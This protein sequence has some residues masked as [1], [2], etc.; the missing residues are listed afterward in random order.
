MVYVISKSGKPLMP[1]KEAKARKLLQDG[2]AKC[3]RRTPFTIKLN[4]DCEE[5]VQEVVAG[6]DTGSKI[7]GCACISNGQVLYQ[8]EVHL[9]TDIKTR[10]DRRRMYRRT[11]RNRKCR[12][13]K[14]RWANRASMKRKGKLSP[15]MISKLNSH[16]KEKRFIESILPVSKWIL[17]TASFDIHKISNPKVQGKDYQNGDLKDFHNIKQYVLERDNYKCQYCKG[18]SKDKYLHIHHIIF[19]SQGGSDHQNNLITLCKTCHDKL[20]DG[21]I[22]LKVKGKKS[23]TK[24]A[25]EMGIL[26]SQ[27]KKKFEEFEETFGYETKYK[28]ETILNFPKTHHNDAVA[29]CCD[30]GEI[31]K[32]LKTV[33]IKKCVPKG[34]YQQTKGV[35]SEKKIP[36]GKLFGFRKYDKVQCPEGIGFIKGKRSSGA[37]VI[38]DIYGNI[39]K[40]SWSA[41]KDL[42]RLLARKSIIMEVCVAPTQL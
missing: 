12:Y 19:R 42:K 5:E 16:L 7:I 23:I 27:L 35:R 32:S 1:C 20:H 38:S 37:F 39:F 33:L 22:D 34:D 17:E 25:T 10:M 26:K 29:I 3:I 4:F 28:R 40:R 41:K 14:P 24:H 36:T 11:R 30:E 6:I 9:R 21:K 2:K 15:T 13:R 18:K 8:S 31:V